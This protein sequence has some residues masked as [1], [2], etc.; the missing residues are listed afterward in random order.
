MHEFKVNDM[1]C[2]HCVH[3][4]TQA[5]LALDPQAKVDIDLPSKIVRI[6]SSAST[7]AFR[8]AIDEAGYT[9]E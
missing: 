9:A 5:A 1:S 4:I 6:E 7:E 3:A 8:H 2:N